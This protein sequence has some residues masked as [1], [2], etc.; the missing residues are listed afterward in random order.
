MFPRKFFAVVSLICLL[1]F[2]FVSLGAGI[3]S[4]TGIT[5]LN[6]AIL[7]PVNTD[8]YADAKVIGIIQAKIAR[9]F[10]YPYYEVLAPDKVCNAVSLLGSASEGKQKYYDE[11]FM[12]SVSQKLSADIVV[13]AELAR[14]RSYMYTRRLGG[15][16]YEKTEVVL[17]CYTYSVKDG[18]YNKVTVRSY[19]FD[20]VGVFSGLN[21]I[22][23]DLT[24]KMLEK[25]PYRTI[26][27][28]S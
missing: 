26:P 7:P 14:V 19:N 23:P 27:E 28:E 20:T 22:V 1:V 24:D 4:A 21:T 13:V 16:T 10:R 11:E 6:V 8:K 3:S 5:A 18:K 2:I 25:I 9:H 15:D 12:R 17:H